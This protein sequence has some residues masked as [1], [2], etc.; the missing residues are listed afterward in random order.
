MKI[1]HSQYE[2]NNKKIIFVDELLSVAEWQGRYYIL[3]LLSEDK[4][5]I[6]DFVLFTYEICADEDYFLMAKKILFSARFE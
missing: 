3:Y 4:D 5:V 1:V 6:H 2:Y